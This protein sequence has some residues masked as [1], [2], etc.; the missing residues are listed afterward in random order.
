MADTDPD[1][2]TQLERLSQLINEPLVASR[3]PEDYYELITANL[4][5]IREEGPEAI[6]S[7]TLDSLLSLVD[8]YE[9]MLARYSSQPA[10]FNAAQSDDLGAVAESL[11]DGFDIDATD[12]DG[13]TLLMIAARGGYAD[14]AKL[15]LSRG[16]DAGATCKEDN[17]LDA[18]IFACE[19]GHEETVRVL[20]DH[21][22]D[23]NAAY[24]PGSSLGPIGN[25]S[26][27]GV[28]AN[29]GHLDVC[30][31]LI[32]RGANLEV[33]SD[34][35]YTPLMWALA[36]NS[37]A[38]AAA[39]LL[40]AGA[41]PEPDTKPTE[42]FAA[43]AVTPLI[44][45]IRAGMTDIAL[46]LI[47]AKVDVNSQDGSGC[48]ALKEAS[49]AG[50]DSIVDALI[51]A[52][53][54]LN[55]ADDDGWTPLISAASRAAWSTMELLID[56][57]ADVTLVGDENVTALKEVG[58]RRVLRHGIVSLSR[59]L[60]RA[61]DPV[62]EERYD[63]A[64]EI[65]EKLLEAGADANVQYDDD[66]TLI[67]A[68][69][70]DEEF[71]ELLMRYGAVP[72]ERSEDEDED[73]ENEDEADEPELSDGQRLVMAAAK[74]D[75]DTLTALLD[76]GADINHL[77]GD[78]DTALSYS[79]IMLCCGDPGPDQTR[80]LLEQIDLL[81]TRG[82]CIDMPGS[83][84]APLPMVARQGRLGLVNAMLAAGAD[85][86]ATLTEIDPD[87]GK[88][89]LD[90]AREAGHDDTV[91]ALM[92]AVQPHGSAEEAEGLWLRALVQAV[93]QK[94]Q[95]RLRNLVNGRAF[96]SLSVDSRLLAAC[97]LGDAKIARE[98]LQ[99]G[100]DPNHPCEE[101]LG[102]MTPLVMAVGASRSV[103]VASL[104]I[105]AGA[106]VNDEWTE[107]TTPIFE[108][109]ADQFYD[110]A[111]LLIARGANVNVRLDTGLTPLISAARNG[112]S[113]CVDLFLDAGAEIDAV[114]SEHGI[115]AFGWAV[116]RLDLRLA[117]K[118]LARGARPNF[119]SIDTLSLAIAEHGSMTFIAALDERGCNL[120][121]S[122]Q[123]ARVA[124]IAA[125]NPD[126]EVF[127]YILSR[128]ADPTDGND[129]GYT[130]L[131]LAALNNRPTLIRRFLERGADASAR[132]IDGETAL[133]LAIEKR[134]HEA[135][136]ALREF[137][138]E[139]GDY[140]ADAP[141]HAIVRATTDGAL[142][143]VLNLRDSGI[144]INSEDGEG[145]SL[146]MLAAKAEHLGV[147]RSL[148]HLGADI[149]HRNHHGETAL[150]LA[151][152]SEAT[153]IVNSLQE[154][155]ALHGMS[156]E[157]GALSNLFGGISMFNAADTMFGR[158]SH[159]YKDKPPY[160]NE[161]ADDEDDPNA[162]EDDQDDPDIDESDEGRSDESGVGASIDSKLDLLGQALDS[163]Q[164]K[165][166]LPEAMLEQLTQKL[167]HW[168]SL[169]EESEL[170]G[171]ELAELSRLLDLFGL[172]EKEDAEEVER[173]PLFEAVHAKDLA[174]VRKIIKGGGDVNEV[175]GEGYT[176]LF[177][178]VLTRQAKLVDELLKLGADPNKSR[179]DGKGPLFGA[180][181]VTEEKI[182]QTLLKG[183][184][185]VDA[186]MSLDH[187]GI[188]VGGCT[189]LYVAALLGHLPSC[190]AL[191]SS[192][193]SLEAANDL[194]YTPLMG[195]IE[196]DH[197]D[198]IDFFLKSGANVNP[199]VIATME[200]EGLGGA[201]PLY[202][203]TRKENLAVIKKLLKRGV[204]VNRPTPNGWTPLKS[205]AQ[206]GCLEIVEALLEAGAD[207]N[208]ADGTNYTPLMNAVSGEH[209]DIVKVLLK[210]NADPNAQGGDVPDDDEWQA[211]RTALMDAAVSGNVAI[212]R[213][214]LKQ[215]A[216]PNLLNATGCTALHSA[217]IS[218]STDMVSLLLKSGADPDVYGNEEEKMS[219]VALALRRW[220][221]EDEDDRE[222]GVSDVLEL[223]LKKGM[224][225]DRASLNETA[226]YLVADGHREA[227][228]LLDKRGLSVEVNDINIRLLRLV[229]IGD[230]LLE[231]GKRLL[232][233]GADANCKNPHGLPVLSMAVRSGALRFAEMLL[234]AGANV[235][236]RNVANA[237]AYDL[238][239]IYGHGEIMDLLIEHMN[240]VVPPVDRQADDGTT[241]LMRAATAGDVKAVK[242][243]L[244]AGADASRRNRQGDSPLSYAMTQ[245]LGEVVQ[246]L[247][248]AGVERLSEDKVIGRDSIV[249]AGS[250]GAT[251]TILD[252]LDSGVPIDTTDSDGNT[253]LTAGEAHPGVIKVLAKLG[254]NLSHRNGQGKT[255][256]MIAA[257]S[258]RTRV[259]QVLEEVGSPIDAP[260]ELEGFVQGQTMLKEALRAMESDGGADESDGNADVEADGDDLLMACLMGNALTVSK[261]I[262]AG[263]DV[264]YENNEGRTALMMALAGLCGG[265]L[266][267][268]R[269]R[270][271]EQM[272]DSLLVAG[273][274]P[275]KGPVPPLIIATTTG[276]LHLV[277]ALIRAGADVNVP[278]DLPTD[279]Q[280]ETMFANCLVVALAQ[281]ETGAHHAERVGMALVRAGVD[282]AFT[283]NDGS[284]AIHSASKAGMTDILREILDR[285]PETIN[286]QDNEGSTP[287]MAAAASDRVE[288]IKLLLERQANR[289][290]RDAKGRTAAEIAAEAGHQDAVAVLADG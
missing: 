231:S 45:A 118:L 53:A 269:E 106:N 137:H 154:F 4:V 115:G 204:D 210:F 12:A 149:N 190:K 164:V 92:A 171:D 283:S 140:S 181:R 166:Q 103:E 139:E 60:G 9:S 124:F 91:A 253:A 192:G 10:V 46:R 239:A 36:S 112:A 88:T 49:R 215:G 110:L 288:A 259:M 202:T 56:A 193:A 63:K 55:L 264:D 76:E 173:T 145:N 157:L 168:R 8:D 218:A 58:G 227:F 121:R 86:D 69:D 57:G 123:R 280:D 28:A 184:A 214:L 34:S 18:A 51:A 197:E 32:E 244:A 263:V 225:S 185:Q 146:L 258:N 135:I 102:G 134:H 260:D 27:L 188:E 254:A 94:D 116:N 252:L 11:D 226:L 101:G 237:L 132:D 78:G 54:D 196:G 126:P 107:D 172:G 169:H 223:M 246:A 270:A 220:A 111:E 198:V 77:D 182:T 75:I 48:T 59:M 290:V 163:N 95:D 82:A 39:L 183:G 174:A 62:E 249:H 67:D 179:P 61:I 109:T 191:A 236:G 43:A 84:A 68:A 247:R 235:M 105:D 266:S 25:Q 74:T 24:A 148:Y 17:D 16:A 240:Q 33:V 153:N 251:G 30:R 167:D 66:Q 278:A 117:E 6:D 70:S 207:P 281:S 178:A 186:P 222:G 99:A 274:D 87:A 108:T 206:Q 150:S 151:K 104:L 47:E 233:I 272:I 195:A 158:M 267:R 142:G 37:G 152:A 120:V 40:D 229:S 175:D 245:D 85:P 38:E 255:A 89:A 275:N 232:D 96:A 216:D 230:F 200:V 285:A 284:M 289:D 159:P 125:K 279:D 81:L 22:I 133:S 80:D 203:A 211:G 144:S 282:L 83:R 250:Q 189:A 50:L 165:D 160:D 79:V 3:L 42:V 128:G 248:A 224:P 129:L 21:G 262:A 7:E 287:L 187:N 219:A 122:D 90:V 127:D 1:V 93:A 35:G 131:I 228:D 205:A 256:Y 23:V 212:A 26:L 161:T 213:E 141:E 261:Q 138:V 41:N 194:G 44:M 180:V 199:E 52:G 13:R 65:A 119:G 147:L 143:T 20:L 73:D 72:S 15:L 97:A 221:S 201:S 268:R 19:G 136:E 209:E 286:A 238:A 114:E 257:A 242:D 241:A 113:K 162:S 177:V 243:L 156:Q 98:M 2:A 130:P 217:V 176:P 29:R 273:A 265:D 100:A 64:L 155:G 271:L 208:I 234:H 71:C 276:R 5:Q 277:N 31:L 14:L 170:D